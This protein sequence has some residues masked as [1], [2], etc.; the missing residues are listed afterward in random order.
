MTANRRI[1]WALG[2][3]TWLLVAP[4]R[5]WPQVPIAEAPPALEIP[6]A[7][8]NAPDDA[9]A[10]KPP[11]VQEEIVENEDQILLRIS[12]PILLAELNRVRKAC[13]LT[14]K[15]WDKINSEGRS[16]LLE[17]LQK[18]GE[19]SEKENA[20]GGG[21]GN[22][23]QSVDPRTMVHLHLSKVVRTQLSPE[24][25]RRYQAETEKREAYYK[26][27]GLQL[28]LIQLDKE[29][30][31]SSEQHTAIERELSAHTS[32]AWWPLLSAPTHSGFESLKIPDKHILPY[33]T[34]IQKKV[35]SRLEGLN[36]DPMQAFLGLDSMMFQLPLEKQ[37]NASEP[38]Q[39]GVDQTH[40]NP[41]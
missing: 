1:H 4:P 31:L 18:N 11:E 33:I 23:V 6:N 7:E 34:P 12:R 32:E 27:L 39:P 35:W 14:K 9:P 41:R 38:I 8:E 36:L 29:L 13:E 17:I 5:A 21:G 28:M 22:E 40:E 26:Q 2:I 3:A 16:I 24:Q 20:G 37:E 15:Q 25:H 10:P 30:F 19:H